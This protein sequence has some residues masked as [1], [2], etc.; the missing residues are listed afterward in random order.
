MIYNTGGTVFMPQLSLDGLTMREEGY[1]ETTANLVSQATNGFDLHVKPAYDNSLRLFAGADLRQD[2]K[3][4]S[5]FIQPEMRAG[6]RYDFLNGA[7]KLKAEFAC[8]TVAT[9][10]CGDTAFSITGPDPSKGNIVAGG[11]IAVTTGAWSLGVNYD[12]IRGTDAM[13]GV[14]QVATLSL[15]GRI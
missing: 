3:F 1:S 9:G 14:N 5:F 12:Y 2:L 10:S 11:G 13:K 15:L 4:S 6:Y 8:S 7:E